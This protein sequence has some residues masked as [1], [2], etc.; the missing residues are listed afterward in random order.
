MRTRGEGSLLK[1]Y[2]A[3]NSVG[4]KKPLSENWYAQY[5]DFSGHQ[6]R[7]STGTK[8]K[9][10]AAAFLRDLLVE[11][12]K[13][14]STSL[15]SR[16]VTYGDLRKGLL[17]D[18]ETEEHKSYPVGLNELDEYFKFSATNPGPLALNI[19]KATSL[20][21]AKKRKEDGVGNATINRSL[22][23]LRRM[24]RIAFDGDK[25]SKVPKVSLRKEPPPRTGFLER[26]KFDE[27]LPLLPSHLHPL[28][29]FLYTSGV[30]LNEAQQI[31]WAQVDL[32]HRLITLQGEQTKN[33]DPRIV[34]IHP[35]LAL[36]LGELEG[37]A[38]ACVFSAV[39]QRVEWQKACVL[40]GLGTRET[41]KPTDGHQWFRYRGLRLHDLRRSA[42]RNLV[43]AGTIETVVMKI[44]GH[45][46]RS[47]FDRYNIV[48]TNDVQTAMQ[49]LVDAEQAQSESLVKVGS[50]LQLTST[51][52]R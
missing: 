20:D 37:E 24:L 7:V 25:I 36:L 35:H 38:D 48:S 49:R 30:R 51:V 29:I 9:A 52:K 42:I 11:R 27:L 33:S 50:K 26:E 28:V 17:D 12:D 47:V 18:Y 32:T 41:V 8:V 2:G 4:E 31:T 45:K 16:K 40:C 46:T 34:P 23:C 22:S 13:G 14:L 10:R 6:V 43:R 39:N 19:T 44:S 5:Y 3:K 1:I 15:T 21:F